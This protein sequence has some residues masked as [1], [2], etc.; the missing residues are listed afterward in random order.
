MSPQFVKPY[1]KTNKNDVADAEA[2]CEAV[3]LFVLRGVIGLRRRERGS[4]PLPPAHFRLDKYSTTA[5]M[6]LSPS[7]LTA[8]VMGAW[9]RSPDMLR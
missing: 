5:S 8:A 9:V 6:F 1:V 3:A 4:P 2:I 7:C